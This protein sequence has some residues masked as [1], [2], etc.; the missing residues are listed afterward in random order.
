MRI[1]FIGLGRMGQGMAGRLLGGGHDLL[2]YNRSAGKSADLEKAGAKAAANI[3]AVCKDRDL[4]ISMVADDA[5]LDQT[6]LGPGGVHESLPKSA[7]YA[8]MG[9][10]SAGAI[11]VVSR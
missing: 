7:V 6:T 5:A 10:H 3:A 9:T 8:A 1:G 2:V 11:Q 4:V